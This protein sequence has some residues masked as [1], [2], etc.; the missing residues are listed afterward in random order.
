M[1]YR[2]EKD[3]EHDVFL[4]WRVVSPSGKIVWHSSSQQGAF[5]MATVFIRDPYLHED[6]EPHP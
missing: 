4:A 1:K 5:H 6:L 2:V 3:R